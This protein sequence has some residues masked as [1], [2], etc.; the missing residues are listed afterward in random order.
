MNDKEPNPFKMGGYQTRGTY[1][2]NHSFWVLESTRAQRTQLASEG[3][4][5]LCKEKGHLGKDCPS[6]AKMFSE[7][8]TCYFKRG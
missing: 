4:C 7:K 2:D 8:K 5:I 6:M 1:A 3:K